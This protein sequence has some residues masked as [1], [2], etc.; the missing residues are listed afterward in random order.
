MFWLRLPRRNSASSAAKIIELCS[1]LPLLMQSLVAGTSSRRRRPSC[2]PTHTTLCACAHATSARANAPCCRSPKSPVDSCAARS[3]SAPASFAHKR[4]LQLQLSSISPVQFLYFIT[5]LSLSAFLKLALAV[6][7]RVAPLA[8]L[9]A[10]SL[11]FS[12]HWR[13]KSWPCNCISGSAN[14]DERHTNK[15]LCASN[16]AEDEF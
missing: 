14:T 16:L 2:A 9:L 12:R 8:A 5:T 1:V 15:I 11:N 4:A 13:A 7:V 6:H 10:N 3:L